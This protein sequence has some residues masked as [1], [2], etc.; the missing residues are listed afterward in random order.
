[1][2]LP[3]SPPPSPLPPLSSI[4]KD[5]RNVPLVM[6]LIPSLMS[7]TSPFTLHSHDEDKVLAYVRV[8]TEMGESFLSLL[9]DPKEMN[10]VMLVELVLKCAR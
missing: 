7:L 9:L 5:P 10:Q 3:V 1:M 6:L 8:F 2:P 4:P